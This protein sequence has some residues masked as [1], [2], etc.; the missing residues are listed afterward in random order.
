MAPRSAA[1][2]QGSF[3]YSAA[4]ESSSCSGQWLKVSYRLGDSAGVFPQ[5]WV[6][7]AV[8]DVSTQYRN[9]SDELAGDRRGY[10]TICR[11]GGRLRQPGDWAPGQ[12]P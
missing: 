8:G 11:P 5:A 6:P 1:S 10:R 3:D 12:R 7:D 4:A 2:I 9:T